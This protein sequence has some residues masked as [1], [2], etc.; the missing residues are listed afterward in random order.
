MKVGDKIYARCGAVHVSGTIVCGFSNRAHD[1]TGR[2]GALVDPGEII[3]IRLD[4]RD[5]ERVR[6]KPEAWNCDCIEVRP[7]SDCVA[8]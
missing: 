8:A 6:I 3:A 2:T 1:F 5:R 7:S 4:D